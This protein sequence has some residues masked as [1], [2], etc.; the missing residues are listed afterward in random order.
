V[1]WTPE[2]WAG[3][4]VLPSP[5]VESLVDPNR[6]RH[7]GVGIPGKFAVPSLKTT[8]QPPNTFYQLP[9]LA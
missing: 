6:P 7:P 8:I 2:G 1:L 3:L 9:C 4:E 5:L